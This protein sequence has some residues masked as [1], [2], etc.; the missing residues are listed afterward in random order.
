MRFCVLL[1]DLQVLGDIDLDPGVLV[2]VVADAGALLDL[3]VLATHQLCLG[4]W[5]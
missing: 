4:L 1:E 2:A 3:S 5:V